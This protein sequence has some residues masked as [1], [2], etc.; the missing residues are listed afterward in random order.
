MVM[1]QKIVE[2]QFSDSISVL[3]SNPGDFILQLR[4]YMLNQL[5]CCRRNEYFG[6]S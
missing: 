1:V 6:K 4:E 2:G 5:L 3:F